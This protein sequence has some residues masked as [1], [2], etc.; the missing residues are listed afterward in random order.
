MAAARQAANLSRRTPLKAEIAS[1]QLVARL[2]VLQ[3]V[4]SQ[5]AAG[6]GRVSARANR[7]RWPPQ[8]PDAAALHDP[9]LEVEI[10]GHRDHVANGHSTRSRQHEFHNISDVARVQKAARLPGFLKLFR[11]P[12]G[13]Q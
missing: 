4:H 2:M 12:I 13:K 9:S 8:Q 10:G 5:D 7:S 1:N 11:R 6:R 3:L